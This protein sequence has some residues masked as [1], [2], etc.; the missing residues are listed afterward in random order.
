MITDFSIWTSAMPQWQQSWQHNTQTNPVNCL[1]TSG[2]LPRQAAILTAQLGHP[3]TWPSIGWQPTG[4]P[5]TGSWLI[6][7]STTR[8]SSAEPGQLCSAPFA[9]PTH[10]SVECPYAPVEVKTSERQACHPR[11]RWAALLFGSLLRGRL[12]PG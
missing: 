12:A 8:P 7:H 6:R 5:W 1:H 2:L 3:M 9:Y 11:G 10:I 4:A